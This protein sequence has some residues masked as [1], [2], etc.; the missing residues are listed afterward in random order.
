MPG[1]RGLER[2]GALHA[3][4]L[5]ELQPGGLGEHHVGHHAGADHHAV[6]VELEARLGD[7]LRRRARR[8]PRSAR[9][10][11][12]RGPRPRAPRARPGRSRPTSLAEDAARR[13]P[14][15]ASRSSTSCPNAAVS[16]AAH[17][18][19]D[20]AAADQHDA[21]RRLLD[22]GRGSRRSCRTRAGSGCP[23][24]RSRRRAAAGRWRRSPAAPCRSATSS[25]V[26]SFA[27]PLARVELHHARARQQLDV[28]CSS[29]HS[30]GRKSASSLRLLAAQVAPSTAAA[31]RTAGRARGRRAAIEPSAPSSRSQRAQLAAARPPPISR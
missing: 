11:R 31:G 17:L 16:D 20:V 29:H 13:S 19:A 4:A 8:R 1:H 26:E 27:T 10:R 25:L 23:R 30:S 3:P 21:A 12:R 5:A 6:A 14:P 24:G 7:D 9:A 28:F 18:A 2:R 22:V 15:P